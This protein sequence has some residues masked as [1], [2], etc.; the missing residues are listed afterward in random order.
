MEWREMLS[1]AGDIATIILALFAIG[2]AA[3]YATHRGALFVRA[4]ARK[5]LNSPAFERFLENITPLLLVAAMIAVSY[6]ANEALI[7]LSRVESNIDAITSPDARVVFPNTVVA[8]D[9]ATGCPTGW[10][11][12]DPGSGRVVVGAGSGYAYRST[13]GASEVTLGIEHMP[14]HSHRVGPFE[15]GY[16]VDDNGHPA[17]IDVDDGPPWNGDI[18]TLSAEETGGGEPHNNMPPYVALHLCRK[19]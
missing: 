1:M 8:Y 13:G 19:D 5:V 7:R 15:W 18:G 4:K 14:V 9:S 6:M 11:D 10:S 17:R 16:D 12:F 2:S 3:W